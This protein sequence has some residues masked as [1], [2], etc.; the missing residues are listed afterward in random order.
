MKSAWV[1]GLLFLVIIGIGWGLM[2][3]I[4]TT[5]PK[6]EENKE[7]DTRPSVSVESLIP[8]SHNVLITSFGEVQP[9]EKTLIAAQVSGEVI[10]WDP[11]FVA[12]GIVK[13]GEV[14]FSIEKDRYEAAVLQAQAQVSLA[15]ASLIEEQARQKVAK[16]ESQNLPSSQVS[17]LYLRKPQVLS[18]QAQLKFAQANLRLANKDLDNC[19]IRAPYHALII[20]R[21]IGLGQFVNAGTQVALINN[22]ESAEIIFPIAGFDKG[23]VPEKIAQLPA[24]I[25]T[26][27][28]DVITRDGILQRDLG[29]VDQ[30][31]RMS[32]LVVRVNDPYSIESQAPVLQFGSFVEVSF[33][34][35]RLDNV[36]KVPQ[37]L[38]NK[39]RVW[40]L[41]EDDQ[42]RSHRVTV[43]REEGE[44]FFLSNGFEVAD[45]LVKSL[46]EYPQNGME[47]NVIGAPLALVTRY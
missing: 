17:D 8:I 29:V 46:P 45:R 32:H 14:L 22:I 34:G 1:K 40:L 5:E 3:A 47:V 10:S 27:G 20:S 23:F 35:N 30:N 31:T 21:D 18:A 39:G 19:E 16:R 6:A 13:R 43:I 2:A 15:Q 26:K 25:T 33:S 36:F 28:R 42:M 41:D 12:G 9:L 11:N 44:F 4:K 37:F 24:T 38:V 7:V